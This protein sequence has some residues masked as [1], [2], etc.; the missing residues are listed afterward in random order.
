LTID[1][2]TKIPTLEELGLRLTGGRKLHT[3]EAGSFVGAGYEEEVA[4]A[5]ERTLGTAWVKR[6]SAQF[7]ITTNFRHEGRYE[8]EE[9]RAV[10]KSR[11]F[12]STPQAE[13]TLPAVVDSQTISI[14]GPS[15]AEVMAMYGKIRSRAIQPMEDWGSEEF[16]P[17]PFPMEVGWVE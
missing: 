9:T 6:I 12:V 4:R 16:P 8:R 11:R 13:K 10:V 1:E 14:V 2:G 7:E 5:I 17:L 3:N 15:V